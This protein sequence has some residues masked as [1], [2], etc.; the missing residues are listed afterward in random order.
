MKKEDKF[1]F[2]EISKEL[3]DLEASRLWWFNKIRQLLSQARKE[4]REEAIKQISA[5]KEA[6]Q[7]RHGTFKYD[8]C[9]DDC[10][11]ILN[12]LNQKE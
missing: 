8:S 5:I 3:G 4:V 9:Y 12:K 10:I 1:W 6:V 7:E 2:E 11:E